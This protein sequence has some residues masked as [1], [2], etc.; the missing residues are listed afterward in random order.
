[1]SVKAIKDGSIVPLVCL[2]A[3]DNQQLEETA[4]AKDPHPLA[5]GHLQ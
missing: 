3:L 4:R 5:H 1:M 2:W